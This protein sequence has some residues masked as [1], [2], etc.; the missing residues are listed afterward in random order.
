MSKPKQD[1]FTYYLDH[2]IDYQLKVAGGLAHPVAIAILE[3]RNAYAASIGRPRRSALAAPENMPSPAAQALGS[4][5]GKA[6]TKA[7]RAARRANGALGG[8]P[9][10][11]K[12]DG[13]QNVPDQPRP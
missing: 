4:L 1:W 5:G 12:A 3:V 8:R 9:K 10:T 13:P 11:K 7:Q 2:A 6:N